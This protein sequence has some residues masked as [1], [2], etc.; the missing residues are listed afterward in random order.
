ML[1]DLKPGRLALVITDENGA[2]IASMP[3]SS[4]LLAPYP[5]LR[6]FLGEWSRDWRDWSADS[7]L[8]HREMPGEGKL[9]SLMLAAVPL[10]AA[11][12]EGFDS[13]PQAPRKVLV[14]IRLPEKRTARF[15]SFRERF[16]LTTAE[17]RVAAEAEEG[18]TPVE[19]AARLG[20]SVHTVRSHLK[21]IFLKVGVHSEAGL[22]RALLRSC[23]GDPRQNH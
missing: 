10:F 15:T 7:F 19:I 23:G 11:G 5:G 12:T 14:C 4:E 6:L 3:G 21:R 13:P 9:G 2:I 8:V 22:V 1:F 20:L 16:D 18:R 17:C